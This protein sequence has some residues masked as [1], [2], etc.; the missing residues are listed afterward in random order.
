MMSGGMMS[1]GMIHVEQFRA[2]HLAA[3]AVQPGQAQDWPDT[4]ELHARAAAFA[5]QEH[6]QSFIADDGAVIACF[7]M[8]ASHAQHLTA[9]SVLSALSVSQL[10]FAT[11]WCRAY[12]ARLSV[13]RIDICVRGGFAP[14]HRWAALLGFGQEG[15]QRAFY[16]DG[17]DLHIWAQIDGRPFNS[18]G[19]AACP[20]CR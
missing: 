4:A 15:V 1:E 18:E 17:D 12:L 10:R 5:L 2:E 6:G 11:R 8:I 14:G 20:S 3:I 19:S 13:R 16:P 7:G 9:W